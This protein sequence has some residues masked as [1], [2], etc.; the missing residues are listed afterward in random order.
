MCGLFEFRVS[1]NFVS[2]VLCLDF[3][4]SLGLKNSFGAGKSA[5]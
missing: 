1:N 3:P 5:V 2:P 4:S